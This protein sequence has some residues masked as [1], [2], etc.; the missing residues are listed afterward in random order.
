MK[1]FV[2]EY[3]LAADYLDRR[4]QFRAAHLALAASSA[5]RGDLLLAGALAEPADRA[6]LVFQGESGAAAEAFAQNDPYVQEGLVRSWR[7]RPWMTVVGP[8]AANPL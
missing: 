2:L 3:D 4:A 5:A 7:V 8:W 1:H 6:L